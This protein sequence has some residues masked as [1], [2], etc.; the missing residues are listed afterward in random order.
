M[1]YKVTNRQGVDL[2]A[3]TVLVNLDPALAARFAAHLDKAPGR[4]RH[5][6]TRALRAKYGLAFH[7]DAPLPKAL[8][9][10]VDWL[11]RPAP[12]APTPVTPPAVTPAAGVKDSLATDSAADTAADAG[13]EAAGDPL[14]APR[15]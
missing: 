12:K 13:G 1:H 4:R 5:V 11:D 2:P 9:A 10:S 8:L 15:L 7:T 3:G 14:G 6:V